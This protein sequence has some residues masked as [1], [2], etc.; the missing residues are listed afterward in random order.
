MRLLFSSLNKLKFIE[1][2]EEYLR[3]KDNA[4][5]RELKASPKRLY[6]AL[7]YRQEIELLNKK[8]SL[9]KELNKSKELVTNYSNNVWSVDE[10]LFNKIK[11]KA[12]IIAQIKTL[13]LNQKKEQSQLD[14][15]DKVLAQM[16][17][18]RRDLLKNF[19]MLRSLE[20]L[21]KTNAHCVERIL[22][23]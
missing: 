23:I 19:I 2:Y 20:S 5:I 22:R 10:T 14:D 4:I 9:I 1:N 17:K 12:E 18:A 11:I 13:L 6:M 15:A 7:F 21:I 8:E 3:Y 16:T